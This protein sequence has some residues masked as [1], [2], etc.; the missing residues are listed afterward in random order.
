M[1]KILEIA[2]RRVEKLKKV[3]SRYTGRCPFHEDDTPSL[4]IDPEKDVF[5]CHGCGAGGGYVA[6]AKMLGERVERGAFA[7]RPPRP[8]LILTPWG[9]FLTREQVAVKMYVPPEY[10][11]TPLEALTRILAKP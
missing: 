4:S 1:S 2:E 7:P 11:I 10:D 9:E 8:A 6:F 5:Y 3:G